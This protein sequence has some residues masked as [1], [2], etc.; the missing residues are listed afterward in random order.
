M[1]RSFARIPLWRVAHSVHSDDG[2]AGDEKAAEEEC[3][4]LTIVATLER[5]AERLQSEGGGAKLRRSELVEQ[6]AWECGCAESSVIPSDHYYNWTNKGLHAYH[7]KLFLH[8][9]RGLYRFVGRSY[10]YNGVVI[11]RPKGQRWAET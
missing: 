7:T 9:G 5:V 6:V 1:K 11:H 3:S 10:P 4:L 2:S 8:E